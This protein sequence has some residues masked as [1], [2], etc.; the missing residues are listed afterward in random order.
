M[1]PVTFAMRDGKLHLEGYDTAVALKMIEDDHL[2]RQLCSLTLHGLDLDVAKQTLVKL[3]ATPEFFDDPLVTDALWYWPLV[4]YFK[5]FGRSKSRSPLDRNKVLG[6]DAAALRDF[7]FFSALRDKHVVH[8]E[9]EYATC[10]SML[11]IN[12]EGAV[13]KIADVVSFPISFSTVSTER[14]EGLLRLV[15]MTLEWV[16]RKRDKLHLALWA[17]YEAWE[18]AQ[19]L[20]LPDAKVKIPHSMNVG[21]TRT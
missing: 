6:G 1:R 20:A 19:L 17:K 10:R 12:P 11:V 15:N 3:S 18:R 14:L 7:E 2:A 9:N 4:R 13:D 21:S 16:D 5:C 8:D